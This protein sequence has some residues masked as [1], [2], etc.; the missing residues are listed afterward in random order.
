M[1][2]I[3]SEPSIP[4]TLHAALEKYMKLDHKPEQVAK[5]VCHWR[6]AKMFE[7]KVWARLEVAFTP[8]SPAAMLWSD[9]KQWM[10]QQPKIQ[11]LEGQAPASEM[12][13]RIQGWLD[14]RTT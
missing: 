3:A 4:P 8:D 13:R 6:M 2:A 1:K 5:E 11:K 12:E 10:T 7:W 14:A 9:I